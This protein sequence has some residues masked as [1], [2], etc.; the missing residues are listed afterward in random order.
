MMGGTFCKEEQML[1]R[2]L[3]TITIVTYERPDYVARVNAYYADFDCRVVIYDGSAKATTLNFAN[4]IE[5]RHLPNCT[6]GQRFALGSQECKTPYILPMPDDD[7]VSLQGLR[8]CIDYLEKHADVVSVHGQMT[9]FDIDEKQQVV[10]RLLTGAAYLQHVDRP[11]SNDPYESLRY[12]LDPYHPFI[13]GVHRIAPY[14]A[15]WEI[16]IEWI[17][18]LVLWEYF[19][20]WFMAVEGR[21][22][23]LPVFFMSRQMTQ[24]RHASLNQPRKTVQSILLTLEEKNHSIVRIL[25]IMSK[26]INEKWGVERQTA[27]Y[28]LYGLLVKYVVVTEIGVLRRPMDRLLGRERLIR[29]LWK[30]LDRLKARTEPEYIR[31]VD[32]WGAV[33]WHEK[34]R[35]P[36][37]DLRY[38]ADLK[39]MFAVLKAKYS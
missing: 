37:Y 13:W 25:E 15:F 3:V 39:K 5:Y 7:L 36:V 24:V 32:N 19:F 30:L 34:H 18:N 20:I 6:L 38:K 1:L 2:E 29:R 17:T 11:R 33:Y 27:Q 12:A 35:F 31:S 28:Y 9:C 4:N 8:E 14:R 16:G 21:L 23:M 26:K 10:M 22:Q